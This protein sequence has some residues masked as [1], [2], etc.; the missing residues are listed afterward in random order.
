MRFIMN[1]GAKRV[2]AVAPWVIVAASWVAIVATSAPRWSVHSAQTPAAFT[3]R[4]GDARSFIVTLRPSSTVS[5]VQS[6]RSLSAGLNV[7]ATGAIAGTPRPAA[8]DVA[9]STGAVS[10]RPRQRGVALLGT[11]L[12]CV[13]TPAC[14]ASFRVTVRWPDAPPTQLATVT[15]ALSAELSGRG[16][17]NAPAGA[18][19]AIDVV[20]DG[21]H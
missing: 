17:S 5:A 2:R 4:G 8:L 18:S 9:I 14:A 20:P 16:E 13:A 19:V 12:D 1:M 10:S 21:A 3:L 6:A 15:L 11:S 7:T